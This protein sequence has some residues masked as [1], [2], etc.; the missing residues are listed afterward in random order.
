MRELLKHEVIWG[1]SSARSACC[2]PIKVFVSISLIVSSNHIT[3]LDTFLS[4]R[5][6]WPGII[7]VISLYSVS[8]NNTNTYLDNTVQAA[9]ADRYILCSVSDALIECLSVLWT[10]CSSYSNPSISISTATKERG[11]SVGIL[12]ELHKRLELIQGCGFIAA[13]RPYCYN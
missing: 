7:T 5:D 4:C 10:N 8:H 9:A 1:I 3:M 6:S 2:S 12:N 11:F 13:L